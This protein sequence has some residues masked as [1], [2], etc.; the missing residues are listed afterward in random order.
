MNHPPSVLIPVLSV[1]SDQASVVTR[2]RYA[3]GSSRAPSGLRERREPHALFK[4]T[5]QAVP[6]L[7]AGEPVY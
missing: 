3:V 4:A 6:I 7:R 2:G 5:E 1:A